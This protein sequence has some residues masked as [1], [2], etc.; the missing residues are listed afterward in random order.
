MRG[1][2]VFGRHRLAVVEFDAVAHLDRPGLGVAG[3]AD[4][5]GDQVFRLVVRR[6]PDEEFAPLLAEAVGDLAEVQR[7]IEA[8]GRFA[9]LQAGL[10]DAALD[11]RLREGFAG[12]RRCQCRRHAERRGA[13]EEVAARYPAL[14]GEISE[15]V[16][17][18]LHVL[19]LVRN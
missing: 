13:A 5:L 9:A 14:A 15:M 12:Q 18:S 3:S 17:F 4:L 16:E 8:V 6:Q 2:D 7:R 1:G 19:P 10:E 11:R